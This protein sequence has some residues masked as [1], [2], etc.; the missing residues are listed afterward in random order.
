MP[1]RVRPSRLK[2]CGKYRVRFALEKPYVKKLPRFFYS[3][4]K[5]IRRRIVSRRNISVPIHLSAKS[6]AT[7]RQRS[8]IPESAAPNNR[9]LGGKGRREGVEGDREWSGSLTIWM[10]LHVVNFSYEFRYTYYI[11]NSSRFLHIRCFRSKGAKADTSRRLTSAPLWSVKLN[12]E[13]TS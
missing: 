6:A 7:K 3:W 11:F 4:L 5:K 2:N 9:R 8:G 10:L 12:W 13:G 1:R